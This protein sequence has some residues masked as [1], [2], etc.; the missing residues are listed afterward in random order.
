MI[1]PELAETVEAQDRKEAPSSEAG[2]LR[3]L[4]IAEDCLQ[5]E[6]LAM[7]LEADPSVSLRCADPAEAM[8][9]GLVAQMDAVLL[10]V[11][12]LDPEVIARLRR[13]GPGVPIIAC[14]LKETEENV[15]S[16]AEAGMSGYVPRRTKLSQF[17]PQLRQVLGGEQTCLPQVAARL[18]RR[19]ANAVPQGAPDSP[20]NRLTRRE[21]QIA[22][23]ISSGRGDK[24]IA[25]LL[26]ISLATTK[27]HVHNLLRKLNV[28]QR[29][30]VADA[31]LGRG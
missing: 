14:G 25:R 9:L 22:E 23:L 18:L 28:Q 24:E 26:N 13:I 16:W 29:G 31:L 11:V 12:T 1:E 7:V 4:L 15:I 3:L 8:A 21:R 5:C 19:F 30:L 10:C 20:H 17:L 2:A 27:F 6:A